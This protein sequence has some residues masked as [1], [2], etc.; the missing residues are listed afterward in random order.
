MMEWFK[1]LIA[2]L[3]A[4]F[5]RESVLRDIEEELRVHVEMETETNIKRGMPPDEARSAALKSFGNLGRNT[6]RGYDIRGGGWLE[7]LWQDLRYSLRI[8][9]KNPGFSLVAILTLALGIG[10][11]AAIFNFVNALLLR[12]IAGV[13]EPDRLV[14]ILRSYDGGGFGRSFSYAD[15][16]DYRDQNTTLAGMAL[17]RTKPVH[18][19]AGGVDTGAERIRGSLASGNYFAVLGVKALLGRTLTPQDDE[20]PGGG[21]VAVISSGLWRRRFGADPNIVGRTIILNARNYT[22]IGV[23]AEGFVG[24]NVGEVVEVWVPITMYKQFD[25]W[26]ASINVDWLASRSS[27]WVEA[28]AR[29]KPG[30]T[31]AQAQAD[32]SA[33]A[34]RLA[35]VYPKTNARVEVR[36]TADV[37]LH[38]G[39]RD[40]LRRFT[41]LLMGVVGIVL[42]IAC[43][44]VANLLLARATARRKEISVRLALGAGRA[45]IVKQLFTESLLLALAGGLAGALFAIWLS[46]S[47]RALLPEQYFAIPLEIDLKPDARVLGFTLAAALL[48]GILFGLAPALQASRLDL[49]PMLKEGGAAGQSSGSARLRGSLVGAQIALSL[50]LLVAAGLCVRTLRNAR[51]INPGFETER[52]LTAKIDLG[53]QNY[54]TEQGRLFYRRLVERVQTLPGVQA[55]G[56]ALGV[57]FTGGVYSNDVYPEGKSPEGGRVNVKYSV[58]TPHYFETIGIPLPQGRQFTESDSAG[59]P[60]VAIINQT[61][62]RLLWPNESPLGKRFV[63]MD[64]KTGGRQFEVVGVSLDVKFSLFEESR[65]SIYMPVAQFYMAQEMAL[66]VRTN[67][68]PETLAA[69]IER[70]VSALDRSLPVYEVRTLAAQL[71]NALTP[72]RLA[73]IFI[74]GFGLLA[75]TLASIGL[76]S[77][78]AYSV[79]QRTREIGIRM[80]LG[81]HARDVIRLVVGQGMKLAL[82]GMAIGL[83][84]AWA[85]TRWMKS[86]LFEVSATDPLTYALIAILLTAVTLLACWIPARRAMRVDPVVTLKH[87]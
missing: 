79:A 80:A 30:V 4:L 31:I 2:R 14:Q 7:T 36:L 51:A 68:K 6:E 59:A 11:N 25:P 58:V 41:G 21:P 40:S 1:I 50:A 35:Q 33:V 9:L 27:T 65:A 66:H 73:A 34:A 70:E 60:E 67:G 17:H 56:L 24:A 53:R 18:L 45:R 44:N 76:Y 57:P 47:L 22:V 10:A 28:V 48:T 38:P 82:I 3:R 19:S 85:L 54:T 64:G 62:A 39:A 86:L 12:P 77:V 78:M 32:L 8:L 42:L 61:A 26:M 63:F 55:A 46:Y 71:D 83:G 52:V 43:A 23:A 75:V 5:R 72:Q 84:I 37:G 49:A 20:T 16:A 13:A 81:A 87:E 74:S 15:F 69:A 29:L